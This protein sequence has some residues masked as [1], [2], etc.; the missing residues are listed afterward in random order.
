MPSLPWCCAWIKPRPLLLRPEPDS[1][2]SPSA[3]PGFTHCSGTVKPASS[4]QH[5]LPG[6]PS[7]HRRPSEH[8][9]TFPMGLCH[10]KSP[11]HTHTEPQPSCMSHLHT[12]DVADILGGIIRSDSGIQALCP[13]PSPTSYCFRGSQMP[14]SILFRL[15]KRL[16]LS[17]SITSRGLAA[18]AFPPRDRCIAAPWDLAKIY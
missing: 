18:A 16:L 12:E 17:K 15:I 9:T 10:T 2:F 14:T 4:I 5:C 1:I 7:P 11:G 6:A 13:E 3:S 8:I